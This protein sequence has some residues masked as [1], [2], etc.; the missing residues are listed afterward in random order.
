[1]NVGVG[2]S[3]SKLVLITDTGENSGNTVTQLVI[4]TPQL[5]EAIEALSKFVMENSDTRDSL[6]QALTEFR[7]QLE[8]SGK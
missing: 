8:E 2:M 3:V 4:P 5:F 7:E 6:I 1:M